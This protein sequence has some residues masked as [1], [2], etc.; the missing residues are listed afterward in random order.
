M[1]LCPWVAM[2]G[3][4]MQDASYGLILCA[5]GVDALKRALVSYLIIG[6]GPVQLNGGLHGAKVESGKRVM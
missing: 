2:S 3:G 5:V 4:E 6:W 1:L